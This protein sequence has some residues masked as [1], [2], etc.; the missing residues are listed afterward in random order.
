MT[1]Q[2]QDDLDNQDPQYT[3]IMPNRAEDDLRAYAGLGVNNDPDSMN[4]GDEEA[5]D[6]LLYTDTATA[7]HATDEVPN[8]EDDALPENLLNADLTD[9]DLDREITEL[10]DDETAGQSSY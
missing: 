10:A 6:T 2:A 5:S 4:P 1:P 9:D 3:E 7:R 8:G